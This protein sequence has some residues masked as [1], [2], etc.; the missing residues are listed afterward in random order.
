LERELTV[1]AIDDPRW[2]SFV[3]SAPDAVPFHRPEW[4]RLLADC[5][6]HRAFALTR[7]DETGRVDDGL[8]ILEIA[9]PWGGRQWTSLPFTDSCPLL[10]A[11]DA[12]R[13]ALV[14][15]V[16]AE[17]RARGV[18]RLEIRAPI[19]GPNAQLRTVGVTHRLALASDPDAMFRRFKPAVQ[20]AIAKAGRE[21]VTVAVAQSRADLVDTFYRLHAATRARLGVPV[22]PRRYFRMLWAALI[23]SGLGFVLLASVA[24]EPSP[25]ASSW[26]GTGTI[27]YKYGA[28]S[29]EFWALR[30]N[31]LLFAA[32]IRRGCEQGYHTFDFGRT[33]L[34]D[35]GLRTFKLG[36]G[37]VEEPL[38]YSRL[39]APWADSPAS[40]LAARLR[41][42]LRRAPSWVCRLIGEIAYKY[43]A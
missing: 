38:V 25:R 7:V 24:T 23:E 30:P 28:S 37:A 32:A 12:S 36:W 2:A 18:T 26:R 41:P 4:A 19:L 22:Q 33:D 15:R 29:P 17:R 9:Y 27:E 20:R 8:P 35:V 40:R 14:E 16:D 6:G 43:A 39:G 1:L 21:G 34:D 31:N 13:L 42:V 5:Y 3:Q 11:S 10:A